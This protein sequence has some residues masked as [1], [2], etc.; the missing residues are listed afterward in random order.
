M[1][2]CNKD[3][4]VLAL[5]YALKNSKRI[6]SGLEIEEKDW[7]NNIREEINLWKSSH[8]YKRVLLGRILK[9]ITYAYKCILLLTHS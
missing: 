2:E 7:N 1:L 5:N 4:A 6:I 9:R 8:E 3:Y